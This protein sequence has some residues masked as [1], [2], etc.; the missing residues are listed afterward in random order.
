MKAEERKDGNEKDGHCPESKI[1]DRVFLFVVMRGVSEIAG[2][3]TV[4]IGVASLAGFNDSIESHMRIGVVH[5]LYIMCPVAIRTFGRLQIAQG[6]GF[7]VY[8]FRV[9]FLKIFVAGPTLVGHLCHEL[10][11]FD[12]LD[13]VG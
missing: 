7:T 3:S 12:L 5:L 4:G 9:G 11:L 8:G 6:I 2:K 10:V 1:Q 13:L